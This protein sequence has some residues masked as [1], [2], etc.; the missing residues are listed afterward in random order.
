MQAK[1]V[2][3]NENNKVDCC[4][5]L[6]P[7]PNIQFSFKGRK[8]LFPKYSSL[9]I[10]QTFLRCDSHFSSTSICVRFSLK[11]LILHTQ[12]LQWTRKQ[13]SLQ[14]KASTVA[15]VKRERM[16]YTSN[17]KVYN[18][19]NEQQQFSMCKICLKT[20]KEGLNALQQRFLYTRM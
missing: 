9:A 14:R 6:P 18:A 19:F 16:P 4:S 5:S 1:S 11:T 15:G 2:S 17:P 20:H 7:L 10:A 12:E 13:A 3:K 8:T